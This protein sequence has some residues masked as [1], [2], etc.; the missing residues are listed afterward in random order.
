MFLYLTASEQTAK[1]LIPKSKKRSMPK[2][3]KDNVK[4]QL[5]NTHFKFEGFSSSRKA[6]KQKMNWVRLAEMAFYFYFF[7]V[8][9]HFLDIFLSDADDGFLDSLM[10]TITFSV[11][12]LKQ[13]L[14]QEKDKEVI[15]G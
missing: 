13:I 6:N 14:K 15:N 10:R 2:F 1:S 12:E 4:I 11:E 3:Y 8:I 5:S 9:D 7:S